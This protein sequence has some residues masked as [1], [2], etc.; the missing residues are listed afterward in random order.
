MSSTAVFVINLIVFETLC[1]RLIYDTNRCTTRLI[2]DIMC[3]I[4]FL[5]LEER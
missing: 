5:Q 4:Y 3:P 1:E 2:S